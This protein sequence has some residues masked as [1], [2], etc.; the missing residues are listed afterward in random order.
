MARNRTR[1][2]LSWLAFAC[3]GLVPSRLSWEMSADRFLRRTGGAAKGFIF[4]L[5]SIEFCG[6]AFFLHRFL[7]RYRPALWK[8]RSFLILR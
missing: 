7:I 5:G 6:V 4:V 3:L 8:L 2:T 1:L